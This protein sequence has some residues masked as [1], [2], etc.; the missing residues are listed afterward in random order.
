M[1]L[2]HLI[3][4][5]L[6]EMCVGNFPNQEVI[7][8][9][10]IVDVVNTILQLSIGDYHEHGFSYIEDVSLNSC[11]SFLFSPHSCVCVQIVTQLTPFPVGKNNSPSPPALTC[12]ATCSPCYVIAF[13]GR[14][15]L[16]NLKGS[17]VELIEAMLEETNHR[18]CHLAK[19]IAGSLDLAAIYDTVHDFFELMNDELVK[20]ARYDDDAERGLFRAYHVILQLKDYGNDLGEWGEPF[21]C[22]DVFSALMYVIPFIS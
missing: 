11:L 8:N 20:A 16:V 10:L 21:H 22:D 9:R 3:L 6:I 7:Y 2:V 14:L 19:E 18:S 1:E 4:Q 17:A 5:T 15:Q 12:I 13:A